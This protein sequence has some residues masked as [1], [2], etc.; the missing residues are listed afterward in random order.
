MHLL[1]EVW[2]QYSIARKQAMRMIRKYRKSNQSIDMPL[3]RTDI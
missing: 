3:L 2:E 1:A